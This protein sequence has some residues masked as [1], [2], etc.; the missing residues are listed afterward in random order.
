MGGSPIASYTFRAE[1]VS[2]C[3]R[4]TAPASSIGARFSAR[5][6]AAFVCVRFASMASMAGYSISSRYSRSNISLIPVIE[7]GPRGNA[8]GGP[9]R[10]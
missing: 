8:R 5:S 9:L 3:V 6:R 2:A 10:A 4:S 1:A 7:I